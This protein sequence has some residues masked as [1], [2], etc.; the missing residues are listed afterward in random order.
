V[1]LPFREPQ[2]GLIVFKDEADHRTVVYANVRQPV[3]EKG[4][5]V[6]AGEVVAKVGNNGN[7]R[8]PHIHVGAWKGDP[9]KLEAKTGGPPL[10]IQV[11]LYAAEPAGDGSD[12][13]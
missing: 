6:E 7:S 5:T 1:G 10:Q 13:R 4:E 9:S 2:P 8:A 3:V 12:S 11:D